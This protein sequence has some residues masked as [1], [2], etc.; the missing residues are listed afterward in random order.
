[1]GTFFMAGSVSLLDILYIIW[2]ILCVILFFK[3]WIACEN[4]KRLADKYA[5]IPIK[6]EKFGT[7]EDI[8]KWLNEEPK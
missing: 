2:G 7:K 5:P 8:D 6:K 3:V 4:I 1:M